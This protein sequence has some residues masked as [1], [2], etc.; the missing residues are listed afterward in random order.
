MNLL[1]EKLAFQ[2][3]IPIQ[4]AICRNFQNRDY[5]SKIQRCFQ[6][7]TTEKLPQ[8]CSG[9]SNKPNKT[10]ISFPGMFSVLTRNLWLIF[11][12]FKMTIFF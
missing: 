12:F 8:M 11:E 2:E 5:L 4:S 1:K 9:S 6:S 7:Q 3:T 10:K